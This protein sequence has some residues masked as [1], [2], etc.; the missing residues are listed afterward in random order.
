VV[1]ARFQGDE[2]GGAVSPATGC[3]QR[4]HFGMLTTGPHVPS[5]TDNLPV[6]N[7]DTANARI[8]SRRPETALGKAQ[9]PRHELMIRRAERGPHQ[10]PSGWADRDTSRMTLE[11]WSTSSK[12]R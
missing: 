5:L 2:G 9:R 3:L 10:R 8:R 11:N 1:T 7:D 6:A 4:M 12:F